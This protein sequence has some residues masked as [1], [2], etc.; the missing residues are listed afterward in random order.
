MTDGRT[1]GRTASGGARSM[2]R[3]PALPGAVLVGRAGRE[4]PRML[5]DDR[6]HALGHLLSRPT[7]TPAGDARP[8]VRGRR[9]RLGL[10]GR[11]DGFLFVPT[12]YDPAVPAPLVLLLHG[13]GADAADL[14]PVFQPAAERAGCVVAAVDS[15]GVTWDSLTRGFGPDVEFVD[16]ARAWTFERCAVDAT[17]VAV[18]GFSDGASYALSLGI[19]NGELLTHI[20]AF[21][22]G[23]VAP[24]A[25]HGAPRLFVAH[26]RH[27][28]VLPID[29]CSRR[30]VPA[31]R[32]AGYDV[33]YREFDG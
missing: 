7:A 1:D 26:G 18:A 24:A 8:L 19:T 28:D 9:Q 25:Q 21:S 15:R 23:F 30:I 20:M 22:P 32:R 27:D 2:N 13:A 10:G 33:C 12:G 16:R 14:L 4:I 11:R 31:L 5:S 3:A 17:R 6:S 29:P